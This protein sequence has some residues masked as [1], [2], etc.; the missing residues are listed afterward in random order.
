[1]LVEVADHNLYFQSISRLGKVVDSG[2]F[3]NMPDPKRSSDAS[4]IVYQ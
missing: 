2:V 1:M 3:P 4:P